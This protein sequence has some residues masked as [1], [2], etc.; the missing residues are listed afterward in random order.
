MDIMDIKNNQNANVIV[1][2]K[3]VY[4][5]QLNATIIGYNH[6]NQKEDESKEDFS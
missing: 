1:K 5:K 3:G 2:W 4:A 6:I